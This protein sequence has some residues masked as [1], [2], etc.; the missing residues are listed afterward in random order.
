MPDPGQT[1]FLEGPPGSGKTAVALAL[2]AWPPP[3]PLLDLDGVRVLLL[4]CGEVK[5]R[6][7]EE[8][9][10]LEE[11]PTE[12]EL[13]AALSA[14]GEVLLLLDG[15]R[16][17]GGA[18]D[19]SLSAFMRGGPGCRVLITARPGQCGALRD[20]CGDATTLQLHGED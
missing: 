10:R 6:L 3:A 5:G 20:A 12:E 8:V 17:G 14:S 9:A 7:L 19:E 15:Y 18:F 2:S 11:A 13:E 16:E 4:D 1:V